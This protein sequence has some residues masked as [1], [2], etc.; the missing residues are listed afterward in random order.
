MRLQI[1]QGTGSAHF[2]G[3]DTNKVIFNC[4]HVHSP[5]H[6][7]FRDQD[8]GAAKTLVFLAFPMEFN[9]NDHI[10][11]NKRRVIIVRFK[12]KPFLFLIL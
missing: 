9:A 6:V 5:D 11:K 12:Y 10:F 2:R 3:N 1:F 8:K 4:E 7:V